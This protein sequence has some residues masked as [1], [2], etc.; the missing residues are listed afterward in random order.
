MSP[1]KRQ[2]VCRNHQLHF[3][4]HC[5]RSS[6]I[7]L[8][9]LFTP[10]ND[11]SR[12]A[13]AP[14]QLLLEAVHLACALELTHLNKVSAAYKAWSTRARSRS[15]TAFDRPPCRAKYALMATNSLG[16]LFQ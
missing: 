2:R 10:Q 1:D 16:A 8:V 14:E 13:A 5:G 9:T 4:Q 7:V 6:R 11:D 12:P 3:A 15:E